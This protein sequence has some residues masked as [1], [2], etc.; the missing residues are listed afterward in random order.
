MAISEKPLISIK[1]L[2]HTYDKWGTEVHALR[3]INIDFYP[4]ELVMLVGP[5]GAGK[6]TLLQ[7]L[8]GEVSGTTTGQID[9]KGKDLLK[10]SHQYGPKYFATIQ[11]DPKLSTVADLT[12]I[13]HFALSLDEYGS[14]AKPITASLR[15][16]IASNLKPFGLDNHLDIPVGLLSGG[17]RQ[18]LA[19]FIARLR[20]VD[21]LLLDEPIAALDKK[22]AK[23][24]LEEIK[25]AVSQDM[26]AIM[27]THDLHAACKHGSR[28][29]GLVG[30]RIVFDY[31]NKNI[32]QYEPYKIW[33]AL[34]KESR[35]DI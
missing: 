19:L 25:Q 4:G 3:D 26:A 30:G 8:S 10:N 21:V 9:F 23:E 5:N 18:V 20:K 12:V 11:Q 6:T 24:C 15:E 33:K 7:I 1:N 34:E 29:I 35:Y 32:D 2:T 22:N 14:W 17:E 13:E 28:L 27:I 31:Q 16:V